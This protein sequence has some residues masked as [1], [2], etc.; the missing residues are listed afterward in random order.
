MASAPLLPLSPRQQLLAGRLPRRLL[1][2]LTG[3]VLYGVSMAMM[4]RAQLGLDPWDV[5]HYGVAS[6]LPLTFG[7]VTIIVG[8]GVLVLWIPLRQLPGLGTV[9]NVIVIGLATDAALLLLTMPASMWQ[10]VVLLTSG[11]ILNGLAGAMYIGS[12]LGPG[13]RDGLMTG[14]VRRTGLSVALVRTTLE[15]TVLL[16]GW[17]MGGP[18]GVGTAAYALA[19][20][21]IV[22]VL[23]PRLTIRLEPS[24]ETGAVPQSRAAT[25]RV[26]GPETA[27]GA[28]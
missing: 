12:Q 26:D 27:I 18:V 4:I 22:H 13:P 28:A 24:S 2:L 8:A 7:T 11:I 16:V 1:Q 6:H 23:L 25:T 5:F 17:L 3:L 15:V 20:G 19:I 9:A 14:V 21:P 10:R